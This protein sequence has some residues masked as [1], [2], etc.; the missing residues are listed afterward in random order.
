MDLSHA[1]ETV[2]IV[3]QMAQPG[4]ESEEGQRLLEE[5]IDELSETVTILLDADEP[6]AALRLVGSISGFCQDHGLVELG[7]RLAD[8]TLLAARDVGTDRER[9]A[10]W[11]TLG[12][13]AFRQGDQ[14]VALDA[15]NTAL[16][17]ARRSGERWLEF[18]AQFNL[19]RIAFSDGDAPRIHHHADEM[20]ATAGDN[21]RWRFGAIHMLA[22][23]E[24][25][26]GNIDRAIELFEQNVEIAHQAGHAIGEGGELI[27]LGSLAIDAG[28]LTRAVEYLSRGL[29]V[30]AELDSDYLLPGV[31][32]DIGRVAV[33]QG[34]T[35]A[36]LELIAAGEHLYEL[37]G[38][39][40]DPGD[41]AFL[42]Q[43]ASAVQA[44]G[45]ERAEELIKSGRKLPK[46]DAIGLARTYLS[47]A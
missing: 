29:D 25:T 33:L 28:D 36:G 44:L 32:A 9:A 14:V 38:L 7:R 10:A 24:H 41:D 30:A 1:F 23:A 18:G 6:G 12:E 37:A 21:L 4:S 13:L 26:A 22:W 35:E 39:T 11:L 40:P 43:R 27:N 20:L 8:Q 31:V 42:E 19:A 15:T 34:R 45:N 47:K 5:R 2:E 16:D 17:A 46:T 3:E